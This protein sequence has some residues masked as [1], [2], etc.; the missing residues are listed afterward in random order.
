MKQIALVLLAILLV[1]GQSFA[2][3]GH[4]N[5]SSHTVVLSVEGADGNHVTGQTIR[6]TLFRP[7]DNRYFDW[8]DSTWDPLGSVTTLHQTMNENATSGFYFY[9]I[10]NDNGRIVSGEVVCTVSNEAALYATTQSEVVYFD[11]LES[12]VKINR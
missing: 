6:L 5:D 3:D 10:S 8:S 11:R 2:G 1:S 7:R 4:Q 9:Q 12:I